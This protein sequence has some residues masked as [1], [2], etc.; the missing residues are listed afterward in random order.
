MNQKTVIM[1]YDGSETFFDTGC[2]INFDRD[3]LLL[4][5]STLSCEHGWHWDRFVS[6]IQ[7][8]GADDVNTGTMYCDIALRLESG[9]EKMIRVEDFHSAE[10]NVA[11]RSL[12]VKGYK[13]SAII[14]IDYLKWYHTFKSGKKR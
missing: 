13:G 12:V 10:L 14:N 4:T 7:H 8:T 6:V 2:N 11:A 9:D 5:A 1:S 3:R